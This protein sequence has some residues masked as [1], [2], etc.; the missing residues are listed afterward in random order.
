MS[1]YIRDI[2]DDIH[3]AIYNPNSVME[4]VIETARSTV[5]N[6]ENL[7]FGEPGGPL[8]FLLEGGV[9]MLLAGVEHAEKQ[10]RR[11][12]P[13]MATERSE[14]Y[15]HM[16]D[17]DYY[18]CFAVPSSQNFKMIIGKDE[19]RNKAVP[20]D[21]LDIRR[22]IIP[23]DTQ[24]EKDGYTF[25]IQYPIELRVM[26]HG[27][28]QV[29]YDTTVRSPIRELSQ[30]ALD[31]E[32]T[33]VEFD[34]MAMEFISINIP[35]LQYAINDQTSS[36]TPGIEF[37]ETYGFSDQ[38]FCA[39]VWMR[40]DRQW[41]E[42]LTTHSRRTVD[43]FKPTAMLQVNDGELEVYIP[44]IYVRKGVVA[45]DIRVDIYTTRGKIDLDLRS[46]TAE[47]FTV[48]Y[49]DLNGLT[50][51]RFIE[52][53]RMLSH[54][55]YW[56]SD[57]IRGGRSALSFL[58]LRNRVIDNS[59][60]A[61]N[62]PISENQLRATLSDLNYSVQKSIDMATG[63]IY[64]ASSDMPDSTLKEVST[65]IG[66]L[67]GIVDTSF[68]ELVSLP[69]VK[70]NG[71]RLTILP[72]TIYREH[73]GTIYLDVM[74]GL[75]YYNR[76][77]LAERVSAINNNHFLFTP[78]H[79]VLD[80]NSDVFE[81]R[82][83]YLAEPTIDAKRFIE[84]NVSLELDVGVGKYSIE[85][86]PK[87][88]ELLITTRS[89]DIYQTLP[90]DI[91]GVQISY[92]PRGFTDQVAYLDGKF[93]GM[94]ESERVYSFIIETD[95][96]VDRNHDLIV[97]NFT[98][99]GDR[100]N[101]LAMRLNV[102][103]NVIFTVHSYTTE[104]YRPMNTDRIMVNNKETGA[105]DLKAVTL[106]VLRFNLG[107]HLSQLWTNARNI[108]GPMDYMRYET[109]VYRTYDKDQ[110]K[111]GPDGLAVVEIINGKPQLVVTAKKGDP[112]IVN[113]EKVVLHEAGTVIEVDGKPVIKEPRKL[114]RRVEIFLF[115]ARYILANTDEVTKY[116]KLVIDHVLKGVS[117][118]IPSVSINMHD[119]TKLYY[120]PKNTMGWIDVR[121]AD[122][123]LNRI[124]AELAF[125]VR[126]GVNDVVRK[127]SS[128]LTAIQRESRRVIMEGLEGRTVS[129][130]NIL[131]MQ[132]A[133][134]GS[135]IIDVD[136]DKMGE[137]RDQATYIVRNP[138][139]KLTL[140]KKVVATPD[141]RV[142][143]RDD[144]NVTFVRLD[145]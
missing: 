71:N 145:T 72:S 44:D 108:P 20:P 32:V 92:T 43:P 111:R 117:T 28:I 105:A 36:V 66:T 13:N 116:R 7:D 51:T 14:L 47:A 11:A 87:G 127:N 42:L 104:Q 132:R 100:P 53:L 80:T 96:D 60:G 30:N 15:D 135:D 24:F 64:H 59:I 133:R 101:N 23:A 5:I 97:K 102:E 68:S 113:G 103:M 58:D 17:E 83:Y 33:P 91:C 61:R 35:T 121:Q 77:P 6:G 34:G 98:M 57:Y 126:F 141:N 136:M 52:P 120:Y 27:A 118:D 4:R 37:R 99:F 1:N 70:S 119:K 129:I 110:Y 69:T 38:F 122:N 85:P 46:S 78:F 84:T 55:K 89:T 22:M 86:H 10:D 79:Y 49:R 19:L 8:P 62:I 106:E 3:S 95:M 40:R 93:L 82:A 114:R 18:D 16:S 50:P 142:D 41:V 112:V 12:Y 131:E 39:R 29:L 56:C 81:A 54:V 25:T 75:D 139:D 124:Y 21:G 9:A 128:L 125:N 45:G 134:M 123:S 26:P 76:L 88:Y 63:R 140:G 137:D 143:L 65:T 144:V 115:D 130:S 107:S 138:N 94:A 31:W 109:P 74:G 73:E 2:A 48:N 67:N 90:V